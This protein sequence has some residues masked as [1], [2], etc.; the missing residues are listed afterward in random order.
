MDAVA[1]Y[2]WAPFDFEEVGQHDVVKR[3]ATA[4]VVV[5]S[6]NSLDAAAVEGSCVIVVAVEDEIAAE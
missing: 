6:G 5:V 2:W 1:L 4:A 3:S